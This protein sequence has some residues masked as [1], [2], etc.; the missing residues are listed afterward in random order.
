M[1]SSTRIAG[2]LLV[3][4]SV[5]VAVATSTEATGQGPQ[6]RTITVVELEKGSTFTHVRNT[7]GSSAR[8]NLQGDLIVSTSPLTLSGERVGRLHVSCTTTKGARDFRRS[9]LS[10]TGIYALKDGTLTGQALLSPRGSTTEGAITGGTG[11]YANA[12]GV[13]T[14]RQ[15]RGGA[16]TVFTLA[17]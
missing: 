12:R 5:V 9:L 4:A 16:E 17:P 10:C 2:A 8:S 6:P 13:F 3:A 11:S 1:N 14:S 15:V 7:R